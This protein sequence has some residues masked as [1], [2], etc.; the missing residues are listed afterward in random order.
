MSSTTNLFNRVRELAIS[1]SNDTANSDSRDITS[2]EV[3]NLFNELVGIGNSKLNDRYLFS[4]YMTKTQSFS[5]A[6]TYQGDSKILRYLSV[7]G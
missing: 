3:G 7:T 2:F 4:G 5:T 6:G 1:E